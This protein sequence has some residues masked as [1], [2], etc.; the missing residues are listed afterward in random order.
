MFSRHV[1]REKKRFPF[2]FIFNPFSD[3][4]VVSAY[5]CAEGLQKEFHKNTFE[6]E[7]SCISPVNK[8][9]WPD[10]VPA[11]TPISFWPRGARVGQAR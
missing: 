8:R 1:K 11:V 4:N 7:G 10:T 2:L 3:Y 6:I 9:V 5:S